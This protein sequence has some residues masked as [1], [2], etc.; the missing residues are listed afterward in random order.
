MVRPTMIGPDIIRQE[1]EDQS[2]ADA[3]YTKSPLPKKT[4][5]LSC[6][7]MSP[8]GRLPSKSLRRGVILMGFVTMC[9]FSVRH[10]PQL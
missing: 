5:V 6:C 4:V 1:S 9:Y 7:E 2:S 3:L 10:H 8:N